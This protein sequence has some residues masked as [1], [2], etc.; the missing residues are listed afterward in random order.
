MRVIPPRDVILGLQ[1]MIHGR[2]APRPAAL[3][4]PLEHCGHA[5]SPREAT[6][7][8]R[9]SPVWPVIFP[10]TPRRP[11]RARFSVAHQELKFIL[12]EVHRRSPILG[13]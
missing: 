8:S 2:S 12:G 9:E 5:D 13:R 4:D 7:M 3:V 11:S 1:E 10:G 6:R